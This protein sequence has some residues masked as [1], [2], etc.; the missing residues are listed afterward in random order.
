MTFVPLRIFTC[1][2]CGYNG[3][4]IW[5][6][7]DNRA[8]PITP[9]YQ[10]PNCFGSNINEPS[11]FPNT[12]RRKFELSTELVAKNVIPRLSSVH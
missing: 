6:D 2:E 7:P 3:P 5:F 4:E 11:T 10:C 9:F 1:N 8:G 12:I